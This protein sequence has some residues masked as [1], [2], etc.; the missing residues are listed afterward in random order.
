MK[1]TAK[2][3]FEARYL[4]CQDPC[5]FLILEVVFPKYLQL[6]TVTIYI[7]GCGSERGNPHFIIKDYKR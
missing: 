7:H 6:D 3:V 1:L 4:T 2:T 5:F